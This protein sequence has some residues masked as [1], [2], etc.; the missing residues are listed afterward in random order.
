[1]RH[2]IVGLMTASLGWFAA[3]DAGFF[4]TAL[5][6]P[7]EDGR[8][9]SIDSSRRNHRAVAIASMGVATV[10]YLLMLVGR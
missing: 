2:A 1:V 8:F 6:A 9:G 10:G 5:M 3:A 4:P 7:G